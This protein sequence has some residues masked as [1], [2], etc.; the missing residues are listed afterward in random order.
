M[1]P[2]PSLPGYYASLSGKIYSD[3][4]GNLSQELGPLRL[5]KTVFIGKYLAFCVK[6]DEK[7]SRMPRVSRCVTEA[8]HGKCPNGF[9]A[10]HIDG[11]TLNNRPENLTW[12]SAQDNCGRKRAH[13]TSLFGSKNPQAKLEEYQVSEIKCLLQ[14]PYSFT[15]KHIAS[16]YGVHETVIS[17]IRTGRTYNS[18]VRVIPPKPSPTKIT[19]ELVSQVK[20]LLIRK[21]TQKEIAKIAGINRTTVWSIKKRLIDGALK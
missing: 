7:K 8:Y 16:L 10:S 5:R 3:K 13:G 11:N 4:W 20:A 19:D 18:G 15:N 17:D 2:I 14:S 21:Y 6:N 12:E 9:H 1:R